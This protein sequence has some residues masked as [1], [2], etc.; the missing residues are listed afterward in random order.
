MNRLIRIFIFVCLFTVNSLLSARDVYIRELS[1]AGQFVDMTVHSIMKDTVGYVW[2]GTARGVERFDGIHV[3]HFPLGPGGGHPVRSMLEH[4]QTGD[5]YAGNT[6]GLWRLGVKD[7]N[8]SPVEGINLRGINSI[9]MFRSDRMLIGAETGLYVADLGKGKLSKVTL[10]KPNSL[11]NVSVKDIYYDRNSSTSWVAT[12][13]GLQKVDHD[14]SGVPEVFEYLPG[15]SN[16]QQFNKIIKIRN[17]LYLGTTD[18]GII[19]FDISKKEFTTFVD[20]GCNVISDFDTDS[21]GNLYV[22]SDGCG[23]IV[24]DVASGEIKERYM[25]NEG[26]SNSLHSNSVYSLYLDRNGQMWVGY[27]Q[28][29]VD[30]TLY[31]SGA[32]STFNEEYFSTWGN[33]ARTVIL[34]G[35]RILL[36]TLEGAVVIDNVSRNAIRIK[37][38]Q[39]RS[40]MVISLANYKGKYLIGTYGGGLSMTDKAGN[41]VS[42]PSDD[43]VFKRGHIFSFAQDREGMLWIGTSSGVYRFDGSKI[44]EHYNHSNSRLPEGNVYEIFFDSQGKGWLATENGLAIYD[45][46]SGSIRTDLFPK[47]FFNRSNIRQIYEDRNHTLYFL[48]DKGNFYISDLTMSNFS[49]MDNHL[50]SGRDVKAI[51][52][53]RAGHIWLATS[54][55]M[56][57][58]DRRDKWEEYGFADGIPSQIFTSSHPAIDGEGNILFGNT[59]GLLKLHSDRL[60]PPAGAAPM[61]INEI[62]VD[63]KEFNGK[64][65]KRESGETHVYFPHH[66]DGVSFSLSAFSYTNPDQIHYEYKMDGVDEEWK[67][68]G[69]D[70]QIVYFSLPRGKHKLHIRLRG[71]QEDAATI[72]IHNPWEWWIWCLLVAGVII[73]VLATVLEIRHSRDIMNRKREKMARLMEEENEREDSGAENRKYKVRK[74][75]EKECKEIEKKLKEIEESEK[76]YKRADLRL[77]DV[78][79]LVGVS[80]FKLSYYFSQYKHTTFF[81][82]INALRIAEF[83][84]LAHSKD[85]GKYTLSAFSE[86]AGFSSRATFFRYFKKL[87]GI[88]P[89]EYLKKINSK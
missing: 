67:N 14:G 26:R 61:K 30:Y 29:G 18:R 27:Y 15:G 56:L 88:S 5:I 22:G 76:P 82:Y 38:P 86:M 9:K 1:E 77:S 80:S 43:E 10:G 54:N 73:L 40:D 32:F 45:S 89:A 36:G 59:G 58:W 41:I 52:E 50:L 3:K 39:L 20:I 13:K 4:P 2:F 12:S 24:I 25:R 83:K 72:I 64:I 49:R 71:S 87:E 84:R 16:S 55:G 57:R 23:V 85:A 6:D 17:N 51:I 7:K 19:K 44:M 21:N 70:F 74:L 75:N 63:G 37:R 28:T 34:D 31:N 48:P 33:S 78:A 46:T 68:C 47:G 69:K 42:F 66:Y 60:G 62:L 79:E 81:I 8:F 11:G 65:E 35:D 53:D